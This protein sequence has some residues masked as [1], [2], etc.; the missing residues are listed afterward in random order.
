V[1]VPD[2]YRVTVTAAAF[3][4]DVAVLVDRVAPDAEVDEQLVDL[5]PGESR[6]FTVRTGASVDPAAFLAPEVLRSANA[7]APADEKH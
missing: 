4:R 1:A 6:T 5:L 3:A 2:G 7:L